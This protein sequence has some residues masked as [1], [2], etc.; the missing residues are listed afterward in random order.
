MISGGR[1]QLEYVSETLC[2]TLLNK[3]LIACSISLVV[4]L[5]SCA[6]IVTGVWLKKKNNHRYDTDVTN[7]TDI[8]NDKDVTN[9]TDVSNDTC[10]LS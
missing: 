1:V 4:F 5:L 10:C 2:D 8:T 7:K 6:T 3:V 9:G